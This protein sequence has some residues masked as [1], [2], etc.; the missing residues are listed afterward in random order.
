MGLAASQA[1]LLF[2]TARK[3]DVEF[4]EMRV[5]NQKIALSRESAAASETYSDALNARKL[6]WAVDGTSTSDKEVDLTYNLLM[7]PNATADVGQYIYTNTTNGKVILDS[8]YASVIG[9]PN[10]NAG[11]L[12]NTMTQAA[13]L[14]KLMGVSETDVAPYVQKGNTTVDSTF[15]TSYDDSDI[16][17]KANL[18]AVNA[19]TISL[20]ADDYNGGDGSNEAKTA[21]L[22]Q[23]DSISSAL[24]SALESKILGTIGSKYQA[25]IE[26]ALSSAKAKT[27]NQFANIKDTSSDNPSGVNQI[28]NHQW[29]TKTGGFLGTG[30][31]S[32][33][34]HH[35][36]YKV[37]GQQIIATF[38]TFFDQ[39]C[40]GHLPEGT[41]STSGSTVGSGGT[42]R[43]ATGGTGTETT[44][45]KPGSETGVDANSNGIGD[46]YEASFYINLYNALNSFG[47]QTN[48]G[49][50]NQ[51]YLQAQI[52][53]G[54]VEIKEMQ[55]DGSWS[56]ISTSDSDSPLRNESDDA[57]IAKAEAEYNSTKLKIDAK[58]Q[59]LDLD[60]K[61]LDTERSALDTEIDS[62]KA[63]INKNIERSFKMFQA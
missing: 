48:D 14:S 58:E 9:K 46:S 45:V 57:A 44:T 24:G 36:N 26:D 51:K 30:I 7:R 40:A 18:L 1:R 31:G 28:I 2:V 47:W 52:L 35:N 61:N 39:A 34:K 41:N 53:Y 10:G 42:T 29:T 5:A 6:M 27:F 60:M 62:V 49:V 12:K 50:Q 23:L 38:L 20:G 8:Q 25:A 32:K 55:G 4:Q 22:G 17:N 63:I 37:S 16:I 21:F 43:G 54:N 11:D 3:S 56:A 13:F 33:T 59:K 15:I 19:T